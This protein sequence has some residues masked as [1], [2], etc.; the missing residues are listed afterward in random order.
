[1]HSIKLLTG[2]LLA[3]ALLIMATVVKAAP[4]AADQIQGSIKDALGRPLSGASLILKAPDE[5][6]NPVAKK[7]FQHVCKQPSSSFTYSLNLTYSRQDG[8]LETV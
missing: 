8:K 6:I 5:T 1:M 3:F 2:L 7:K 4:G